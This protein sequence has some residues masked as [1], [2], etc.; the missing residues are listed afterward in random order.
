MTQLTEEEQRAH[1]ESRAPGWIL[2]CLRCGYTEPWG[3]YGIRIGAK[4]YGKVTVRRC[5]N[6]KRI[7]FHAITKQKT[8][9]FT[10]SE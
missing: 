6:C 7:R 8:T 2:R 9:P 5:V 3:K 1:Y 4:S 10:S